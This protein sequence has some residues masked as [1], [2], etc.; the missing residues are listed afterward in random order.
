MT[1]SPHGAPT[2]LVNVWKNW[3]MNSTTRPNGYASILA[4]VQWLNKGRFQY[5]RW[6]VGH[7]KI[8]YRVTK[9]AVR[10]TDFFDSRQDPKKMKG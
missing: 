5:R 3:W 8:I 7:V 10:V 2:I 4:Q 9:T 6:V 1:S